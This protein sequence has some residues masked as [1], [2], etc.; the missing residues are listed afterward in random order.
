MV[1]REEMEI[2]RSHV[3][4]RAEEDRDP[5]LDNNARYVKTCPSMMARF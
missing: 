3:D 5:L 2:F 1:S 4:H